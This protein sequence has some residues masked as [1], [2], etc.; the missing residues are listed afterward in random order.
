MRVS[1]GARTTRGARSAR[2]RCRV[3]RA[4][5]R[6]ASFLKDPPIGGLGVWRMAVRMCAGWYRAPGV[7]MR[8]TPRF[9][10]FAAVVVLALCLVVPAS[11]AAGTRW[12]SKASTTDSS[13]SVASCAAVATS[14]TP[15]SAW[16]DSA[17]YG[18]VPGGSF[19]GSSG[20]A[21]VSATA[22]VGNESFYVTS[23]KD[24]TSLNIKA[25]GSATTP[26]FCGTLYAVGGN[27]WRALRFAASTG[28]LSLWAAPRLRWP[29]SRR[30][31]ATPLATRCRRP[32]LKRSRCSSLARTRTT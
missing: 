3:S 30:P 18:L 7:P 1:L 14:A 19:E 6:A 28:A 22:V 9:S 32:G 23:K 20:W 25:G 11:A 2:H 5:T 29:S 13:A 12:S 15:F 21:L 31:T 10:L 24:T 26:L 8:C 17:S 4:S 16:G 27:H